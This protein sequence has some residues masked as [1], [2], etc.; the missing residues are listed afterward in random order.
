MLSLK[1]K[2][3]PKAQVVIPKPVRDAMGIR[4]GDEVYFRVEGGRVVLEATSAEQVLREFVNAVPKRKK[5]RG[6][7][8]WDKLYE[9][10]YKERL[11]KFLR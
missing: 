8:D 2:V 1:S 3:G 9:G 7:V 6:R 4:P 10:M 11:G 5:L